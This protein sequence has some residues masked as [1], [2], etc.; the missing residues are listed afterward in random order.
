MMTVTAAHGQQLAHGQPN[1][2]PLFF[3]EIASLLSKKE[4]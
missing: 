4:S 2:A 1:F 3:S